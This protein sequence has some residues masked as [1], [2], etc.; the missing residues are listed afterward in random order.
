M[1]FI[2]S[3]KFY[4]DNQDECTKIEYDQYFSDVSR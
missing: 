3:L 1:K 4:S 2:D